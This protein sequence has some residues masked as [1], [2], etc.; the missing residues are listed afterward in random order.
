MINVELF[1]CSGG[2]AAGFRAAGIEFDIAV[3]RDPDHCDSYERNLGH[4]PVQ[5]D[6]I[7]LLAVIRRIR[8]GQAV[9]NGPVCE[10]ARRLLTEQIDLICADPPCTPWS[11]A[12]KRMGQDDER[13]MLAVTCTL[14]AILKPRRYLIS[15]VPGLEDAVNL[16]AVHRTIGAL[17][18]RGYC[19][20]DFL[21][22][23]AADFGVPQ[24]RHRPFWF[25]H[26]AGPCLRPP[27]PTHTDPVMAARPLLPGFVALKPWVTCRQA[28]GH[29]SPEELG[30]A[31]KMRRREQNGKQVGSVPDRPARVV[32]TSNLSDGNV[33]SAATTKHPALSPDAPATT[34]TGGGAGHS[35]RPLVLMTRHEAPVHT[36]NEDEPARSLT[37]QCRSPGHASTIILNDRHRPADADTPAPTL[38]AKYRGQGA[39]VLMMEPHHPPSHADEPAMTIRA[40]SGGGANRAMMLNG[41]VARRKKRPPSTK[42]SQSTRTIAPDAPSTTVQAREDRKG[43]GAGLAPPGHHDENFAIMS[44]PDAIILSERAAAILQGFPSGW[45]FSGATKKV[46]WGA[47]GMAMPPAL[48][49][50]VARAIVEQD[51]AMRDQASLA[52]EAV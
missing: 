26:L 27:A 24:H 49:E 21:S 9:A 10:L 8:R 51:K 16:P 47:I 3:D 40:G 32:G 45:V 36:S 11:R 35:A 5:C 29:L 30:R 22:L 39:Q 2:M 48:A 18:Q 20:A 15:N 1:C 44:L 34:V 33:I 12:G 14:I 43:S 13:D 19:V 4:R 41:E 25:G 6:V 50:A 42:G 38:G 31:V 17:A 37:T 52:L 28:L 46:R 23:D 7:A